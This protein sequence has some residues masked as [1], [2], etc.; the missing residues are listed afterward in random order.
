[1]PTCAS[2]ENAFETMASGVVVSVPCSCCGGSSA[3]MIVKLNNDDT[4]RLLVGPSPV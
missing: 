3:G 4:G 2:F 1:M